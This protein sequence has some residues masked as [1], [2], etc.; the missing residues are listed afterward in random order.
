MII[1][2]M[3]AV[4]GVGG[5]AAAAAAE[6]AAADDTAAAAAAAAVRSDSPQPS[7]VALTPQP[8]QFLLQS[9]ARPSP[10]L[11]P[12]RPKNSTTAHPRPQRP[13]QEAAA[14]CN[15]QSQ[16]QACPGLW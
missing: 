10:P 15:R 6:T 4:V 11:L 7:S 5:G 9:T 16:Q 3:Q 14:S 13:R 2:V 12:T 8:L 1:A